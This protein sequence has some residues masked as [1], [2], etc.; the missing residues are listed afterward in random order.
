MPAWSRARALVLVLTFGS[1][2]AGCASTGAQQCAKADWYRVGL[3]DG[4]A[5]QPAEQFVQRWEACNAH[6]VQIDRG[7]YAAGRAAGLEEYCTV[8]GGIDAG[9]HGRVYMNV[10]SED[11]EEDFL[12]GYY[13]GALSPDE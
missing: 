7:Q 9:R 2:A 3:E 1:A 12:S 8:P 6:G 4:R 13:L 11:S 10:C 5:G